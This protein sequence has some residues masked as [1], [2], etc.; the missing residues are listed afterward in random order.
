MKKI[1]IVDD[2]VVIVRLVESFLLSKGFNV[3]SESDGL[4]AMTT[5]KKENP[6]LIILD[7]IL[8][9]INGYDIC[10]VLR[11]EDKFEHVPI[12]LISER[13][14]EIDEEIFE[15]T[16]IEYLQKPINTE[17]LLEKIKHLLKIN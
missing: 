2:D 16:D 6:D 3:I 8:P 12:I 13:D 17:I 14:K 1:L 15:K 10:Y 9:E 5:I 7:V 4:S 11:F